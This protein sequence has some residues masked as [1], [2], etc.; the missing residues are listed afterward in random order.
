M[1]GPSTA[2]VVI[3]TRMWGRAA[4]SRLRE[5]LK[6]YLGIVAA[7]AIKDLRSEARSRDI[8]GGW[9]TFGLLILL[10]FSVTINVAAL[11]VE[12]FGPGFLWVSF[13]LVG[14]IGLNQS[15]SQERDRG[16]WTALLLAPI[17]HSAIYF[18][19]LIGNLVISFIAEAAVLAGFF[20]FYGPPIDL[21]G[22]VVVTFLGT[23]GFV[24]VGTLLAAFVA[25]SHSKQLLLP[26]LMLPIVIPVIQL[27]SALMSGAL[28]GSG[29]A[30][31]AKGFV[32]VFLIG[33]DV[34][35]VLGGA[36]AFSFITELY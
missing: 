13:A 21:V 12:T 15:F 19:K 26:I 11:P 7:V 33:Y 4:V 1:P 25:T 35:A 23:L 5:S 22:L 27:A 34:I 30:F 17:D 9:A 2:S 10:V 31:E 20:V 3:E 18:G 6:L 28:I 24:G 29:L 8:L 36:S 32:I 14:T 16:G